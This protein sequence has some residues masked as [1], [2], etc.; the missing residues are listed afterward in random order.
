MF[1]PEMKTKRLKIL[2]YSSDHIATLLKEKTQQQFVDLMGLTTEEEYRKY[3][4]RYNGGNDYLDFR[5]FILH[6]A[7]SGGVVGSFSF[8][9]W[10]P[11]H[12]RAEIGYR[13]LP[14][15]QNQGL[16]R[17]AIQ[18][19]VDHGFEDMNLNRIEAFVAPENRYSQKVIESQHFRR[20][21]L[22][23]EHYFYEGTFDDSICYALLRSE[24]D[25]HKKTK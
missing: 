13:I 23:R 8:H 14:A 5:I 4:K 12:R 9:V 22:M 25:Q 20:E 16:A 1:T 2:V 3:Q 18:A 24:Y 17:E 10:V 19:V 7:L 6:D 15:F 11:Q 21:G